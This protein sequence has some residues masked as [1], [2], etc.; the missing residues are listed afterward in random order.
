M[1]YVALKNE[2]GEIIADYIV[3]DDDEIRA[4]QRAI[5]VHSRTYGHDAYHSWHLRPLTFQPDQVVSLNEYSCE[6]A[7]YDTA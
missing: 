5:E 3:R 1:F 4:R 2:D 6:A 7:Q